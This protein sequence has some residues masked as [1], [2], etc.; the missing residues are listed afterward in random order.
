MQRD[1]ANKSRTRGDMTMSHIRSSRHLAMPRNVFEISPRKI[2]PQRGGVTTQQ[3][4]NRSHL[5]ES[6]RMNV[7]ESTGDLPSESNLTNTSTA[8]INASQ[9]RQRDRMKDV[10]ANESDRKMMRP[11]WITLTPTHK[12]LVIHSL[13][14]LNES[15]ASYSNFMHKHY[16]DLKDGF[17]LRVL[18]EMC[19]SSCSLLTSTS[20][21]HSTYEILDLHLN[22][23]LRGNV[24]CS[25]CASCSDTIPLDSDEEEPEIFNQQYGD[26]HVLS[27]YPSEMNHHPAT[28]GKD[29][30]SMHDTLTNHQE[31]QHQ[32]LILYNQKYDRCVMRLLLPIRSSICTY[33]REVFTRIESPPGILVGWIS[34][35][36]LFL[37]YPQ[38]IIHD[39][40]DVKNIGTMVVKN[41]PN[42]SLVAKL[43]NDNILNHPSVPSSAASSTFPRSSTLHASHHIHNHNGM[44][45]RDE[46]LDENDSDI[47]DA[48]DSFICPCMFSFMSSGSKSSLVY[49]VTSNNIN[50]N[51][52]HHLHRLQ[53]TDKHL[54]HHL[55]QEKYITSDSDSIALRILTNST[56]LT[57]DK[58]DQLT[59]RETIRSKS[60]NNL[61]R[62]IDDGEGEMETSSSETR[63]TSVDVDTN[64]DRGVTSQPRTVNNQQSSS[65]P[66]QPGYPRDSLIKQLSTTEGISAIT[67]TLTGDNFN[68]FATFSGSATELAHE[69]LITCSFSQGITLKQRVLIL[70]SLLVINKN[71]DLT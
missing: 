48:I 32:T 1:K 42:V 34:R 56:G 30:M 51:E 47:E 3:P 38:Y 69:K 68:K 7:T 22:I 10:R 35:K 67:N 20:G 37:S 71:K 49:E 24:N 14:S 26:I 25:C 2:H 53:K 44:L 41:R 66:M 36:G 70:A 21:R 28:S 18:E 55:S 16:G 65:G 6:N 39:A 11:S 59:T 62:T 13:G 9:G 58:N 23:I 15:N 43:T 50:S 12:N 64:G 61:T 45:R 19:P 60:E 46:T 54:T 17:F 33:S 27:S 5:N 57:G 52:L 31:S 63:S 8:T 4:V 40:S 29:D